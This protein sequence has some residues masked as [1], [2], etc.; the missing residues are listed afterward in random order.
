M[1]DTT[2][3]WLLEQKNKEKMKNRDIFDTFLFFFF[4]F[5][6]ICSCLPV[7]ED[8]IWCPNA[9]PIQHFTAPPERYREGCYIIKKGFVLF[10]V[11]FM[12]SLPILPYQG[13]QGHPGRKRDDRC[14]HISA[15]FRREKERAVRAV[16]AA[17]PA[18][19]EGRDHTGQSYQHNAGHAAEYPYI[20]VFPPF[21]DNAAS[22]QYLPE[23]FLVCEAHGHHLFSIRP[24]L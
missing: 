14:Q 1:H 12:L 8:Y 7:S 21:S 19:A 3:W 18:I 20:S 6:S 5:L 23:G 2:I 22:P 24:L 17:D 11:V 4:H 16:G 9:L 10:F 15:R 13:R